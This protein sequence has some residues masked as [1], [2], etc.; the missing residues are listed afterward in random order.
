M[1]QY[2]PGVFFYQY[3]GM[4]SLVISGQSLMNTQ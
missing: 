3:T 2:E 1:M 4:I